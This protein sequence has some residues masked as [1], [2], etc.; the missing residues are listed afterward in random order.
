MQK[1]GH[2]EVELLSCQPGYLPSETSPS[3]TVPPEVSQP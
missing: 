2:E 3:Q 1:E